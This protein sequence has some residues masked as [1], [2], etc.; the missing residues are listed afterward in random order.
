ML[1]SVEE[2]RL[3]RGTVMSDTQLLL[4]RIATLR[5]RLDQSVVPV[6]SPAKLAEVVRQASEGAAHDAAVD[7]AVRPATAGIDAEAAARPRQLTARAR[8]VLERGRELLGRLRSLADAFPF[9]VGEDGS[10]DGAV[11]DRNDPLAVLYRETAAMTDSS[12]RM[13]A[14]FPDTATAQMQ[15]C[16]GV[17]AILSVVTRRTHALYAGVERHRAEAGRVTR[18]AELLSDLE[19][20]RPV[21]LDSFE[22]M[23]SEILT[24]TE[25]CVPLRFLDADPARPEHSV[26]RHSLTVARVVARLARHDP[27]LPVRPLDAVLAALLHDVGMLRVPP[28]LLHQAGLLDDS[29]RRTIE[30]HCRAGA[31]IVTALAPDERWLADVALTHHE[32][33]DGTGYPDGLR[34]PQLTPLARLV[35][36]CDVYAAL[37]A[38]RP[39]RAARDPRTALADTLLMAEQGKLD[40]QHAERLLQLSFYPTG[41]AVELADG[42]IGVVVAAPSGADPSRPVV[43]L[44]LDGRGEPL[45]LPRHLDLA[46]CDSHSIVRALPSAERRAVVGRAFPEWA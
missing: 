33:H 29:G 46:R 10:S 25:E 14:L 21:G 23:A 42:S 37:C 38:V 31:E 36:V 28:A 13:V 7:A 26:S 43:A 1:S 39:Y 9:A 22:A 2:T 32:R 6:D 35:A 20:G 34:E 45:P 27:E 44:L 5:K 41:A 18:L 40:G 4:G 15:L 16:E 24:D 30:F 3:G 8:R 17:E 19:A 11:L 12:L